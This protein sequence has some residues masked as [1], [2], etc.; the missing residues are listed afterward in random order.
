MEDNLTELKRDITSRGTFVPRRLEIIQNQSRFIL[1]RKD[2]SIKV[3]RRVKWNSVSGKRNTEKNKKHQAWHKSSPRSNAISCCHL[4]MF[5]LPSSKRQ[6]DVQ[7]PMSSSKKVQHVWTFS[8]LHFTTLL[9]CLILSTT[10]HNS[11][12]P[13]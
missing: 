4:I 1:V 6:L 8:Q 11:S 7:C 13:L 2:V 3:S 10:L 9:F 12:Q 5:L